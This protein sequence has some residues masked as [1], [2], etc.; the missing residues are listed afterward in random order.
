[1]YETGFVTY[2]FVRAGE[3]YKDR[4]TGIEGEFK[5]TANYFINFIKDQ[6]KDNIKEFN[7]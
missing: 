4:D 5:Y 6:M 1:M 7:F 2:E 3:K